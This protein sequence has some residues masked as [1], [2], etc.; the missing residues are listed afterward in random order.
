MRLF[1]IKT[2]S[3]FTILKQ[4]TKKDEMLIVELRFYIPNDGIFA[5]FATN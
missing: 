3:R 5:D 1:F 4:T 2:V